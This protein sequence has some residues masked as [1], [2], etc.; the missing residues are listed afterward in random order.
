M[1]L[2]EINIFQYNIVDRLKRASKAP[3]GLVADPNF[4]FQKTQKSQINLLPVIKKNQ[5]P[6]QQPAEQR[7]VFKKLQQKLQAHLLKLKKQKVEH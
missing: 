5:N 6:P 2:E 1:I 7:I 3:S 4:G